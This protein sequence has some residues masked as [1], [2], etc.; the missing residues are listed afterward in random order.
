M[1]ARPE[2][3]VV[4]TGM[5]FRV[6]AISIFCSGQAFSPAKMPTTDYLDIDTRAWVSLAPLDCDE[7]TCHRPRTHPF[8]SKRAIRHS[9]NDR[10]YAW[11]AVG[12][13]KLVCCKTY[14]EGETIDPDE[15]GELV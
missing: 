2:L 12:A 5:V 4:R 10:A 6:W 7:W 3:S 14:T 15:L 8:F 1:E 9:E 11:I 13:A